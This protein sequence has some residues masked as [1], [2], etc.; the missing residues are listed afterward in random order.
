[1]IRPTITPISFRLRRN[2]FIVQFANQQ[3]C[4]LRVF[5]PLREMHQYA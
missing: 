3:I 1:M 2:P 5:A 4:A